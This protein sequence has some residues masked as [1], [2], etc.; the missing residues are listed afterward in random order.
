MRVF[1]I[2]C[3]SGSN[4]FYPFC[5]RPRRTPGVFCFYNS[6]PPAGSANLF[7]AT[8]PVADNLVGANRLPFGG[9]V[10]PAALVADFGLH[11]LVGRLVA[12]QLDEYRRQF[13][14][15]GWWLTQSDSGLKCLRLIAA[16]MARKI[17][18]VIIL[19]SVRF[20]PPPLVER[21]RKRRAFDD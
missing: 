19:K 17:K 10:L 11:G 8:I 18:A 14:G 13:A 2:S 5:R 15:V 12:E 20:N 16:T 3:K 1:F 9:D 6:L 7:L 4:F 21:R